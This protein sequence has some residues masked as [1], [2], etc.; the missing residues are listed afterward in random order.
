[1]RI[2]AISIYPKFPAI[3]LFQYRRNPKTFSH[4][5]SR[6]KNH[7]KIFALSHSLSAARENSLLLLAT[8]FQTWHIHFPSDYFYC[9]SGL[10]RIH[11]RRTRHRRQRGGG[12]I[13]FVLLCTCLLQHLSATQDKRRQRRTKK[14]QV[15]IDNLLASS[16][17]LPY[18]IPA[19]GPPCVRWI[20]PAVSKS[21]YSGSR[22]D[23]AGFTIQWERTPY[24][25]KER[26][27]R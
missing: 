5:Q 4:H 10:S 17:A 8:P 1:M 13:N 6:Q 7:V 3:G 20:C 27:C 26:V 11:T 15:R 18:P 12:L 16:P 22:L 21:W 25:R 9:L 14:I 24:S 23:C 2:L 19:A